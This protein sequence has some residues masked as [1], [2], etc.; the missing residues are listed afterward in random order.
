[1][2]TKVSIIIPYYNRP[3]K[4]K[5][6]L[7]SIV[8]QTYLSYEIIVVDDHSDVPF[9]HDGYD[10]TYI[11]CEENKGPG[12]ARNLGL[13]V[14]KGE[15][16]VFLD[17]DDYW[18]QDF[19][20]MCV[21][22]LE[23][24]TSAIMAYADGYYV[25]EDENFVMERRGEALRTN[26]I[27]PDILQQGRPWGTG[28]CVW[29]HELIANIQWIETRN[30]EDYIFDISAAT[31]NNKVLFIHEKLVYYDYSGEDRL[32]NIDLHQNS[33]ERFQFLVTISEIIESSQF[34]GDQTIRNQMSR[35]LLNN[36]I[37]L[38]QNGK[39][40]LNRYS[41]IIKLLKRYHHSFTSM[42][43]NLALNFKS[44]YALILLR[45]YRRVFFLPRISL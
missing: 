7:T 22:R 23:M 20:R 16:I 21:K 43:V 41:A 34:F 13:K 31:I 24:D 44:K 38:L 28:A 30:W 8:N 33:I 4:L 2:D 26:I 6:A 17:S 45:Y 39:D 9:Y 12:A 37:M 27:L 15:F 11:R 42:F 3:E 35:L 40:N 29:R 5:R 19:L 10:L 36:V 18:H 1:M 14:A 32:S 25:D